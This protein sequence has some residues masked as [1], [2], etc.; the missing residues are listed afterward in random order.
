MKS[1]M[2][3]ATLLCAI[4]AVS[5]QAQQDFIATDDAWV[6]HARPDEAIG[7]PGHADADRLRIVGE[8]QPDPF[9]SYLKFTVTGAGTIGRAEL[10]LRSNNSGSGFEIHEATN[11]TWDENTITWNNQ[12]GLDPAII[13]SGPAIPNNTTF[14]LDVS[15]VVTGDGTYSFVVIMPATASNPGDAAT[16]EAK[17]AGGADPPVLRI[18]PPITG[19]SI[20]YIRQSNAANLQYDGN[21]IAALGSA[22]LTVDGVDIPGLGYYIDEYEHGAEP[23]PASAVGD[24]IFISQS[25]SSG[26]VLYHTDETIPIVCTESGLYAAGAPPRSQMFFSE[27]AGERNTAPYTNLF[28]IT[29]N[30]HPITAIFPLGDLEVWHLTGDTRLGWMIPPMASGVTPLAYDTVDPTNPCLAVADAGADLLPGGQGN[31]NPAPARRVVLGYQGLSMNDPTSNG[32]YLL[33]R[34]VQ[35]AMGDPVTAGGVSVTTP[36][37]PT[38]LT[39]RAGD[40]AVE[41]EWQAPTGTIDGYRIYQS[42]TSGSG[43]AEVATVA[44]GILIRIITGLTNGTTYYHVVTAFNSAGESPYSNEAS[45][46]PGGGSLGVRTWRGYR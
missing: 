34:C 5:A 3:L 36:T 31:Y 2:F 18:S 21:V 6:D 41:L 40:G 45:A 20:V 22:G 23:L 24:G 32:I 37:A 17:D 12:P 1:P 11:N 35:W 28:R 43:Y 14:R 8:N 9:R 26:N 16:F 25:V 15:T 39:A 30:T 44:P 29:N 10:I 27:S 13:A 7:A 38:N 46:T 4:V 19:K 42:L 33:Q